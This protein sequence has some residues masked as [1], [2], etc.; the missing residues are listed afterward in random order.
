M[1]WDT[2]QLWD[3][4]AKRIKRFT[5]GVANEVWSITIGEQRAVARL[6]SRSEVDL[7][8]ETNLLSFLSRNNICVPK[9]IPTLDGRFFADGLV[10]MEHLDGTAPKTKDD[11]ERVAQ[12]IQR[13]HELTKDWP[14]RPGWKSSVD[15]ITETRGTKVDLIQMPA[16]G[17]KRCRNAWDQIKDLPQSVVHGDLNT[18]NILM[19][20]DKVALIDWD[21]SRVDVS[22]LDLALPHNA[23]EMDADR[24]EIISQ[25]VSAWEASVCWD[26]DYSKKRLAEVRPV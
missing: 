16:E 4:D 19:S 13:V 17:V 15:L 18:G 3:P 22:S 7:Q 5:N 8:W 9:P 20:G 1:G 6:G 21:E 25:A 14:Q 2:L 24:L 23:A 26:D 11:W 10:V 12:T